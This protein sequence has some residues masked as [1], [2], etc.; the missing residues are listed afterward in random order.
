MNAEPDSRSL[1]VAFGVSLLLEVYVDAY[2]GGFLL[3][4]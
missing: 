2:M 4:E 3:T 1:C